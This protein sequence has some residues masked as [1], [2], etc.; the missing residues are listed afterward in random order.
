[1]YTIVRRPLRLSIDA[2]AINSLSHLLTMITAM[3]FAPLRRLP[4]AMVTFLTTP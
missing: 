4:L 3:S 2:I 1:M